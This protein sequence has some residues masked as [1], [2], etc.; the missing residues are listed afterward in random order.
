MKSI[1]EG[2]VRKGGINR[3]P[4]TQPRPGPPNPRG[5]GVNDELQRIKEQNKELVKALE[6]WQELA[7]SGVF[8]TLC[9]NPYNHPKICYRKFCDIKKNYQMSQQALAKVKEVN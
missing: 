8:C 2:K 3:H 9:G 6:A 5:R 7:G 1:R 4:P